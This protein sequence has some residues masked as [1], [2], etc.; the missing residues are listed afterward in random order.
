MNKPLQTIPS[1]YYTD[2]DYYRIDKE[3]ILYRTWQFVGHVSDIPT[4]GGFFTVNI[5]DESL[6]VARDEQEVLHAF[7]NVCRHRAHRVATGQ[8]TC[9]RFVCPYHA[10]SYS[11][12]GS[13]V[14]APKTEEV[15][16]F[17]KGAVKLREVRLEIFCGLIFVNLDDGAIP[18]IDEFPGLSEEILDAKPSLPG[19][20]LVHEDHIA[21]ACNWKVSVE[22]FSECYHCPVAHRWV[23]TNIWSANAYQINIDNNVVRHFSERLNDRTTRGDL[24]IWFMWPNLAI[25]MYPIHRCISVRHFDPRGPRDTMYSY[26][27]YA[28]QNLSQDKVDEVIELAKTYPDTNGAEDAAIVASVQQGLESRA[29]DVGQLVVT[30][31][32]TPQSEHGVAHFQSMYLDAIS[33]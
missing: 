20:H 32:V 12:D 33:G 21:H 9:Q 2:P 27:W 18:M 28:D 15:A 5:A 6:I 24:H 7:Y 10:W 16:G 23:V 26:L 30:P 17:D 29:Y 3:K 25:E 8:G 1:Y 14:V 22:N 4:P 31:S 19:M 13:L 11:L